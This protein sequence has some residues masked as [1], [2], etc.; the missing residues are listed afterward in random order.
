MP[1]VSGAD[2]AIPAE[3][4]DDRQYAGPGK[5]A[6]AGTSGLKTMCGSM[7]FAHW[8]SKS[9]SSSRRAR[10]RFVTLWPKAMNAVSHDHWC[11]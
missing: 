9:V 6:P 10:V 2:G 8:A 5:Y 11:G 4:R 7:P 3:E 1:D